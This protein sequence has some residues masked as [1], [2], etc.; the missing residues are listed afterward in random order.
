MADTEFKGQGN[1]MFKNSKSKKNIF[2]CIYYLICLLNP[3]HS[4]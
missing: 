2:L 1:L 3:N 4:E